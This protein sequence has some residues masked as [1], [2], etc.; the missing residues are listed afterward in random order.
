MSP[1]TIIIPPLAIARPRLATFTVKMLG[2]VW[3]SA[4]R[5]ETRIR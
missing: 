2:Q 1:R 3:V 5:Q 4:T